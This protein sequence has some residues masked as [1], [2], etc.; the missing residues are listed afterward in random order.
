MDLDL[1]QSMKIDDPWS[2]EDGERIT[3]LWATSAMQG[4]FID[5]GIVNTS[6]EVKLGSARP[7]MESLSYFCDPKKIKN[8][9][10]PNWAP[11]FMDYLKFPQQHNLQGVKDSYLKAGGE[12]GNKE[13]ETIIQLTTLLNTPTQ[14]W[15]STIEHSSLLIFC[16]AFPHLPLSVK[17]NK[18]NA[19]DF[20]RLKTARSL[21]SSIINTPIL[22]CCPIALMFTKADICSLEN[23][24]EIQDLK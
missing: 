23:P 4:A 1:L 5:R 3:R 16:V 9:M 8:M 22:S 10:S 6:D 21:F 13:N 2:K 24:D 12:N 17:D 14:K 11:S 18:M 20:Q 15:L 7:L 19:C